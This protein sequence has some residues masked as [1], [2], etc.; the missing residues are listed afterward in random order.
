MRA[1]ILLLATSLA[2][3]CSDERVDPAPGPTTVPTT[4]P[5][6]TETPVAP[7]P[8]PKREV[9]QRN[10]FGNVSE[11]QN[12]LWDGDFE[13]S[14]PFSDQYG[15]IEP[16]YTPSV[17]D[18]V[19]GPLCRSG[20]KCARIGDG[21]DLV[22]IAVASAEHDLEASVWI[23]FL[24][25]EGAAAPPCAEVEAY[26]LDLAGLPPFDDD[27]ALEPAADVPDETGW[28]RLAA[29]V[30]QRNNKT[31]LYV[32]NRSDW[33]ILVDDAVVKPSGGSIP[34]SSAPA[35]QIE[36]ARRQRAKDAVLATR[37]PHDGAPNAAR[38][39]LRAKKAGA[40]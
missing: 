25:D 29:T 37:R 14:S 24:P 3:G 26:L 7:K 38:D 39:A 17:T 20:V 16:P 31:Y 5:V 9:L 27:E 12:L 34:L 1:V 28:C 30:P 15:W 4:P 10:P 6:D 13:W 36:A 22:G 19:V 23:R 8:P 11:T 40:Q 35:R 2:L 21:A 32:D 18:V 33:P